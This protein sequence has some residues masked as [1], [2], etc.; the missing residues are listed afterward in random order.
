MDEEREFYDYTH[1]GIRDSVLKC[2]LGLGL[3]EGWVELIAEKVAQAMDEWASTKGVVTETDIRK[4]I[5]NELT[6]YNADIA[7]AYENHDKII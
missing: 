3:A 7:Y 1:E 2:G 4:H 5:V 6:T